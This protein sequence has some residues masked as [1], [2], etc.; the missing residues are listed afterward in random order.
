MNNSRQLALPAAQIEA[1]FLGAK[2][3]I[4]P[5]AKPVEALLLA[6]EEKQSWF[7]KV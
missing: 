6:L 3:L 7:S 5:S 1:D 4:M 2:E